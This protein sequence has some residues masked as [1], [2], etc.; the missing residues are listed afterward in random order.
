MDS[1]GVVE[2]DSEKYAEI[3]T[4]LL[5]PSVGLVISETNKTSGDDVS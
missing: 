3:E 4:T 1:V 2:T 5:I